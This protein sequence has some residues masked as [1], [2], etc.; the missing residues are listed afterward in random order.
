MPI[1]TQPKMMTVDELF[2]LPA[3]G[4]RYELLEGSLNM[5]SPAGGR[6]GR[7]AMRIALLLGNHVD[8]ENLGVVFAAETGFRIASE[9][10][11][12][13]AA[14]VSYVAHSRMKGIEEETH[15]L[16]LAPDLVVEV[17]S[18]S[19]T[20]TKVESKSFLWLDSGCRLV[21]LADPKTEMVHAYRAR[22]NIQLYEGDATLDAS[23]VVPGWQVQVA[24]FFCR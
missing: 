6:H 4:F 23:D 16:P 22:S 20:F 24:Q 17:I 3:D 12:V 1:Q 19:D 15:F 5:M 18:P 21:L 10:D 14:D 9:P 13:I 2:K 8:R 11:T 7:V